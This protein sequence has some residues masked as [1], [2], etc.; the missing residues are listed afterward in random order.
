[1]AL[2]IEKPHEGIRAAN[3]IKLSLFFSRKD[4][5]SPR[6]RFKICVFASLREI[7]SFFEL[8]K[9]LT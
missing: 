2:L 1:M 7:F 4:A 9:S 6:I 8:Q 5:K 3:V